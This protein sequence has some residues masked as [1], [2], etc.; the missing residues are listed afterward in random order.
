MKNILGALAI[1]AIGSISLAAS[2]QAMPAA[3]LAG[4]SNEAESSV[5]QVSGRKHRFG[6]FH[7]KHFFGAPKFFVYKGDSYYWWKKYCYSYPYHWKCKKFGFY[8]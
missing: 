2:A 4:L 3:S 1:A 6:K 7:G 5:E 8:Y